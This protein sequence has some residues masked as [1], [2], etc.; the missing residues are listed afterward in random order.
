MG[1]QALLDIRYYAWGMTVRYFRMQNTYLLQIGVARGSSC[2]HQGVLLVLYGSA[3]I[4]NVAVAVDHVT[5]TMTSPPG[6][7]VC[8]RHN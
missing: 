1:D 4:M 8:E 2:W 5:C 6:E 3:L 7:S